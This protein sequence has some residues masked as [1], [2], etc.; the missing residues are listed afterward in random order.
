MNY[1]NG[2]DNRNFYILSLTGTAPRHYVRIRRKN[3]F[4][5]SP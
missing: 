4:L 3:F 2:V 1:L 5:F